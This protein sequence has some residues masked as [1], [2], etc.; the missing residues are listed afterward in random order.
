MRR[1]VAYGPAMVVVLACVVTLFAGPAMLSGIGHAQ[2]QARIELA[3][4]DLMQDDILERIDA[5]MTALAEST[6]PSVVH[7]DVVGQR[8]SG[9][10]GAGWVYDRDGHVITNAHVVRGATR[11]VVE[12]HD[13][14]AEPG[15]I[16]G[17][18]PFTDIAVIRVQTRDGLFPM[19]RSTGE[20]PRAGQRVVA[21]GSP[22]GFKFS[23][24]EGIIS[25][26]GREPPSSS[27][28]GQ[29][30][31]FIQTDA[32]V[33]PGNSGGPLVDVR[34]RVVGMNVAIATAR[35]VG[36]SLEDQEGDSAGISFAIPLSTIEPILDQIIE[37]G[38]VERGFLDIAFQPTLDRAPGPGGS[39][40][41]GIRVS[42]VNPGGPAD[43]AGLEEDDLI[44][45]VGGN[46]VIGVQALRTVV[47][48]SR[49]GSEI[50]MTVLRA[51]ALE[52]VR[53]TLG[54]MPDIVLIREAAPFIAM[55]LGL[56]V[57]DRGGELRVAEVWP[58]G[59]AQRAG[60]ESGD[61]VL[62]VGGRSVD[63]TLEFFVGMTDAG[64]LD[65]REVA[66]SVRGESS[67]EPRDVDV[68]IY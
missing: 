29:F 13:G 14:R 60:I 10:S 53:V 22:F 11:V 7:V 40:F 17:T 23:M 51:G 19:P 37:H 61:R 55:Q 4:A 34:G 57:R 24:S 54:D 67:E 27:V 45:E 56:R 31:N 18:D 25:A 8:R 32:A 1:I 3:R 33:N 44:T 2:T 6:L 48:A 59:P 26:L 62:S 30:T 21:F 20:Q 12:F 41:P 35:S 65:G 42:A 9:S 5:A 38:E 28:Y 52:R 16:L 36:D 64:L 50:G 46:P 58:G 15:E 63:S 66:V 39:V 47:A 68:R 43:L 49:P